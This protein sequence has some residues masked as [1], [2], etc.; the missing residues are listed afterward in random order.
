MM[1]VPLTSLSCIYSD[2]MPVIH[3][4]QI[5]E[6][7]LKNKNNS[8]FYH[9]MWESAAM[10]KSITSNIPTNFNLSEISTR[11][12]FGQKKKLMVEVVL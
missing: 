6:S 4:T 1:D 9:A 10:G 5:P 12:F 2:N 7:A 11:I 3:N 8:I